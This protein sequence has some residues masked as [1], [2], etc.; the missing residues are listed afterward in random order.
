MTEDHRK[1][2]KRRQYRIAEDFFGYLGRHLP[3]QCAS[4]EFY[5]LPRSEAAIHHLDTLDDMHPDKV[6][7]HV[8]YVQD[9]L[10]KL[11][12]SPATGLE[13]EIDDRLLKLSME[14]FVREFGQAQVWRTDPTL[15]AKIP[16][17]AIGHILSQ[18]KCARARTRVTLLNLLRQTPGFLRQATGNL[19]LPPYLSL[20]VAQEMARD[21]IHFY[22]HDMKAFIEAELGGDEALSS[23]N[24]KVLKAWADFGGA[25]RDLPA[26]DAFAVGEEGL[27]EILTHSLGYGKTPEEIGKVAREAYHETSAELHA[28]ATKINRDK[29]WQEII[30][31]RAPAVSS[32]ARLV[33]LFQEQVRALRHFFLKEDRIPFPTGEKL[34]VLRTPH[35]LKSLRATASYSAPLTGSSDTQGIFHVNPSEHD[36]AIVA[37]H[38]PYISAHEA[39]PGHHLLDQFRISHSNPTRR[40]IESPL[41]YEGWAC[42][43]EQ[44]LDELGY[45]EDPRQRLIGLKRRLWRNLRAAL[46]VELQ[47][48]TIALNQ[49]AEQIRA[50]GFAPDRA[51]RQIRR[52]ALTPGYQLCYALGMFELEGLRS[53][54]SPCLG[55]KDFHAVL[56]HGGQLPVELAA[57]R[58]KA[59]CQARENRRKGL[60]RE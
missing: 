41:F 25:L 20:Q 3:Q 39:Y 53:R 21:A 57:D 24:E 11:N 36:L 18:E 49:G 10:R 28:L 17:L 7:D 16:L 52:F 55:L 1:D 6:Q 59:A 14:S 58:L 5:F 51:R 23:E 38:S 13:A 34:R 9:L 33:Q 32:P 29:G 8:R 30:Y 48:G 2:R 12:G 40:Q 22:S 44:L 54:F 31:E 46:D 50:L 42:Y 43:A 27:Q 15:Y 35:Y 47:T 37:S 56:L 45:I 4:D 19:T 26:R 60:T